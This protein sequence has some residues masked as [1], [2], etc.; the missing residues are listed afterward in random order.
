MSTQET[1][2]DF[3]YVATVINGR[4]PKDLSIFNPVFANKA[5]DPLFKE[6]L[7]SF[8]PNPVTVFQIGATETLKIAYRI[9]SGWSEL[10]WGEYVNMYGG[11]ITVADINMDHIAHSSFLASNLKYPVQ[12]LFGDGGELIKEGYDIY[13]LDGADISQVPDAHIQTLNQ[14]K[15][16][17]H[18]DSVVLVDDAPTKAEELIKYLEEKGI[19][20]RRYEFGNGMLKIDLRKV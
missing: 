7:D 12:Y 8:A 4:D 5:R 17:E 9:G 15:A 16:I 11:S 13:Y 10:F 1:L 14:F 20:Y 19:A 6:V 18:T 2:N 3:G